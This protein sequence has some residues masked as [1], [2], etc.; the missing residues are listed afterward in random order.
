M[1]MASD[2]EV[3]PRSRASAEVGNP[4]WVADL[5][6]DFRSGDLDVAVEGLDGLLRGMRRAAKAR[7]VLAG[8][9]PGLLRQGLEISAHRQDS[10]R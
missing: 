6:D 3:T 2:G 5:F 4:E 1:G 8:L 10:D 9:H 7:R